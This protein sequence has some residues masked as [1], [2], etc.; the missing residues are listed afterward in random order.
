[1]G[2]S[3]YAH[4]NPLVSKA[5]RSLIGSRSHDVAVDRLKKRLDESWAHGVPTYEFVGGLQPVD[6]PVLSSDKA[7][8]ARRHVNRYARIRVCH[9]R[10]FKAF[11]V[12]CSKW[13]GRVRNLIHIPQKYI[14]V[15]EIREDTNSALRGQ[16]CRSTPR[17]NANEGNAHAATRTSIPN[18]SP[19]YRV[20]PNDSQ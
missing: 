11:G 19:T 7:V 9:R 15:T 17:A 20:R 16:S 12:R 14:R 10:A 6:A 18:P 4:P 8:E 1:M 2:L 5:Q 3:P 13:L